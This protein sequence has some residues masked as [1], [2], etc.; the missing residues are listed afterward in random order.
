M[1]KAYLNSVKFDPIMTFITYF[2]ENKPKKDIRYCLNWIVIPKKY[3]K[4]DFGWVEFMISI[5]LNP[6]TLKIVKN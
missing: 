3:F 5:L 1:Q 6:A 4:S 2:S